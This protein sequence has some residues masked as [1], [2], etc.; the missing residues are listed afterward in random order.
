MK[1]YRMIWRGQNQVSNTIIIRNKYLKNIT[2][3]KNQTP[4]EMPA[5]TK[6]KNSPQKIKKKNKKNILNI[7]KK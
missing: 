1:I 4:I 5:H 2:T 7:S 6:Y 3:R